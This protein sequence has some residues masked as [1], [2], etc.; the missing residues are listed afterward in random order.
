MTPEKRASRRQEDRT[1]ERYNGAIVPGSGAGW[2]SKGDVR[3]H[4]F[5]IENKLKMKLDAKQFTVKAVDLRDLTKR[6]RLEGRTPMT[7]FDLG[8]HSY[9]ILVEAD[10][11]E[12]I[13]AEE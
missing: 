10:L 9:V 6:A 1:A 7:Q 13:G 8:G 3:T 12:M 5:M 11:L 2:K 4:D